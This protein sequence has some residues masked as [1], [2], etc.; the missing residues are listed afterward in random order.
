MPYLA[1]K[2]IVTLAL[3]IMLVIFALN[4]YT[5]SSSQQKIIQTFPQFLD[6]KLAHKKCRNVY[7]LVINLLQC[8]NQ[9]I[10]LSGSVRQ[11]LVARSII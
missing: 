5:G 7:V 11:A 1:K 8:F 9:E 6:L 10:Q 4:V 3:E 2:L